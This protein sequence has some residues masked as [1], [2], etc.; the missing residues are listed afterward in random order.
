MVF[1]VNANCGSESFAGTCGGRRVVGGVGET[2]EGERGSRAAALPEDPQ[3]VCP[4]EAHRDP[5]VDHEGQ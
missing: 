2:G 1:Q 5:V 3:C 4:G